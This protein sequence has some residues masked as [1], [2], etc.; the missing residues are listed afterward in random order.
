MAVAVEAVPYVVLDRQHRVVEVGPAAVAGLGALCG[1]S[2]LD[3]FPDARA[4]LLPYLEEAQRTGEVV[5]FAQYY[6][7][8]VAHMKVVPGGGELTVSW[9]CAHM[10]D[11]LTLDRLRTSLHAVLDALQARE[12]ALR[13]EVVRRSLRVVEGSR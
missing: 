8:Y 3:C 6:D 7:G 5:E 4:L 2:V 9:D 12:D 1:Q 11:V 13:R 10:L